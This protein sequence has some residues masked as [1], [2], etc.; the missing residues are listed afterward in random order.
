MSGWSSTNFKDWGSSE[1]GDQH[2]QKTQQPVIKHANTQTLIHCYVIDSVFLV[3][4]IK[5]G[6]IDMQIKAITINLVCMQHPKKLKEAKAST[7]I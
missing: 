2:K 3:I 7:V 1:R 6:S 5:N 4:C